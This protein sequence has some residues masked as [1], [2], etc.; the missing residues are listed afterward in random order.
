MV[1]AASLQVVFYLDSGNT[2]PTL[3]SSIVICFFYSALLV[4]E[5]GSSAI[6]IRPAI[7]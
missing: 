6:S 5:I 4:M 1:G 3:K 2:N 7:F